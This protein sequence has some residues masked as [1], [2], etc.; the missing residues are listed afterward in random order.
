MKGITGFRLRRAKTGK[1]S[2][3]RSVVALPAARFDQGAQDRVM[4][5]IK[6]MGEGFYAMSESEYDDWLDALPR[7][8]FTE[9]MAVMI[10]LDDTTRQTSGCAA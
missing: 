3:N 6:A 9:F 1:T 4:A 5:K 2:S 10:E 8:E 7:A